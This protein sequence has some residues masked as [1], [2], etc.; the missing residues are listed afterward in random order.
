MAT[1]TESLRCGRNGLKPMDDDS[2]HPV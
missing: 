1:S 2:R